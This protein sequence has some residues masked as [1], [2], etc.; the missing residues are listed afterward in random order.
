MKKSSF[1]LKAFTLK[2]QC[3]ESCSF[4]V[5]SLIS[6]EG[7]TGRSA[8]ATH[9]CFRVSELDLERFRYW[10]RV[11]ERE[12][13]AELPFCEW[14]EG[15][16]K[17]LFGNHKRVTHTACPARNQGRD[18]KQRQYLNPERH[19]GLHKLRSLR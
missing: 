19:S 2:K 18:D 8:G 3:Y 11:E 4:I 5:L 10:D 13:R 6:L 12:Q 9:C 15:T 17:L 1:T 7:D 14:K 16:H